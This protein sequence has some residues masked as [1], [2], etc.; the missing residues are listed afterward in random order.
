M[1]SCLILQGSPSTQAEA[2]VLLKQLS[3]YA[4]KHHNKAIVSAVNLLR[5][6]IDSSLPIVQMKAHI[7]AT[8]NAARNT[9]NQ[10][11]LAVIMNMMVVRFFTN[12]VGDQA[13]KSAE[14]GL[15]LAR[16]I[17]SPLWQ[18]VA[19]QNVGTT[20]DLSGRLDDA[21]SAKAEAQEI[22]QQVPDA[23][24]QKFADSG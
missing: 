20:M 19:N 11:L 22:W 4:V 10:Q 18:A 6:N 3:P 17:H 7:T 5:A 23:I 8:L 9:N 2:Q 24:R 21:F 12:T 13:E 1:N 15:K 16:K 14:V